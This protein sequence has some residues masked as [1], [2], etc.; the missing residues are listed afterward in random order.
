MDG[1]MASKYWEDFKVGDE[2]TTSSITITDA[3]LVNW[4]G[5]TMDFY[6]LHMDEE[7]AKKT[8]FK[9]RIAHGPLTFAMAIGLVFM[10]GIYGDSI[11]AWLGVENMKIPAPVRIGDTIRVYA[12]VAEK[13][14]TKNPSRGVIKFSWEIKN[15]RDET[16]MT[17]DYILMIHR[18]P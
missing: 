11:L 2:V 15:Q 3:H 9:G 5:L 8:I 10:T 17:L 6:P 14:E 4:A 1:K 12:K 7:Y 13:R 18:K 16:V